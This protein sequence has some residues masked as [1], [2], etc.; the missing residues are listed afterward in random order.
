MG[1]HRACPGGAM[2]DSYYGSRYLFS[3][4]PLRRLRRRRERT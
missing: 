3:F 2:T 4:F 1:H